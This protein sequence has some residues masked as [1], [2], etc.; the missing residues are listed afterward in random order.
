MNT[1]I[2]AHAC[3]SSKVPVVGV[4]EGADSNVD[5]LLIR[6]NQ[7]Y[8]GQRLPI[9]PAGSIFIPI[10]P[11]T[12]APPNWPGQYLR[13]LDAIQR[14][15]DATADRHNHAI[16]ADSYQYHTR[17]GQCVAI[18]HRHSG[19]LASKWECR[20]SIHDTTGA[21]WYRNFPAITDDFGWLVE[22]PAC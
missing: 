19:D 3:T 10:A 15:H 8:K 22:V 20:L 17:D 6:W 16:F 12:E 9:F 13:V 5:D 11:P 21:K 18:A 7:A 14:T 2:N 4:I 1:S